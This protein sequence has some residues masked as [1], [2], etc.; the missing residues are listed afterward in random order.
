MPQLRKALTGSLAENPRPVTDLGLPSRAAHLMNE[1][2]IARLVPAAVLVPVVERKLG[3]QV[4]LTQRSSALRK[5]AGE[6]SLPGG[7]QDPAD[8]DSV[9]T[10]LRE[11]C[12]EI[13]LEPASVEVIGLLP[14]Y[15]TVTGYRITPV[16]GL[17]DPEA[18][19]VADGV[20]VTEVFE[21]PLA[22]LA[23]PDQYHLAW[24]RRIGLR[25]SYYAIDYENWHIW[26]AT[27]GVLHNLARQLN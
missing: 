20:E 4:L 1:Q 8:E 6:I 19:I 18:S 16:V 9:A 5:H 26:G 11:S 2:V 21:V 24:T 13:G 25:L 12:E 23:D 15:P 10:A 27:A 3:P 22:L 17:V 14:D 7:R